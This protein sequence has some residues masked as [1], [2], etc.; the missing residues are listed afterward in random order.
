MSKC[1]RKLA[2]RWGALAALIYLAVF[3]IVRVIKGT[4]PATDVVKWAPG[5]SS[6]EM[7]YILPRL[8]DVVVVF[9]AATIAGWLLIDF[10]RD[11]P[12][13]LF[14]FNSAGDFHTAEGCATA[15]G[16]VGAL[17]ALFGGIWWAVGG[18]AFASVV[19]IW[20]YSENRL[21]KTRKPASWEKNMTRGVV[22]ASLF[23]VLVMLFTLTPFTG[24]MPAAT[25]ALITLA[26]I[27][28]IELLVAGVVAGSIGL[29]R[30]LKNPFK[31]AFMTCELGESCEETAIVQN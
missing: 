30:I 12:D 16:V 31:Q 15:L 11:G 29:F 14:G 28:S 21:D 8:A 18:A 13:K 1:A 3:S 24:L 23:G 4:M 20:L 19:F 2:P 6:I 22:M 9:V 17:F 26:V 27:T 7:P 10:D 5:W 25:Y